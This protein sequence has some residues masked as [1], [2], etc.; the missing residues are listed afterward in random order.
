MPLVVG[1]L[2]V[3][4][5][6]VFKL[7]TGV[8]SRLGDSSD[9]QVVSSVFANDVAGAQEL[10][11]EP[12]GGSPQCG[13][14]AG[15]TQLLGLEGN[16]DLTTG[17]YGFTDSYVLQTVTSGSNPTYNLVRLVCTGEGAY[18]NTP[19][20][21]TVLAYDFPASAAPVINCATS[22]TTCSASLAASGWMST[23]QVADI[24]FPVTEPASGYSYNLAASPVNNITSAVAGSPVNP[25]GT[26]TC[27]G[28]DPNT[29]SLSANLCFVDFTPLNNP[30]LYALATTPGG[31]AT[32]S[33]EV[34]TNNTL[35]FCINISVTGTGAYLAPT[36]VPNYA[37]A[38]LGGCYPTNACTTPFYT[39][40]SGEP[41][42]WLNGL[43][44]GTSTATITLTNIQLVN[45]SGQDASGWQ[46]ISADAES[47]D[48]NPEYITWSTPAAYPLTPV[49]NG[50]TV[51]YCPVQVGVS[52]QGTD[53]YG[54]Y[55]Y[56]GNACLED[57]ST[58]GLIQ[59]LNSTTSEIQCQAVV[60][61]GNNTESETSAQK[62]GAGMVEAVA[63]PS[64]TITEGSY[65]GLQAVTVG[66]L[67][68]GVS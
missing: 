42:L 46:L 50:E 39:G 31:C 36:S 41:A 44:S 57:Q 4:I 64:M 65:N 40:I 48:S 26:T 60:K 22:A 68:S 18:L 16:Y 43:H 53:Q 12:S 49:C 23:Q 20:S 8:A 52:H 6:A 61:V 27:N 45:S 54:N 47:T 58:V 17:L 59:T 66:L 21:T 13:A 3:G 14:A 38:F 35:F 19:T 11:T 62:S 34:G 33:V 30:A 10:T 28:A 51:D 9:S 29:G 32:I 5:I 15:R 24:T 1:A 25:S 2:A 56:W 63:P 37:Q 7:Q 67:V 55:D